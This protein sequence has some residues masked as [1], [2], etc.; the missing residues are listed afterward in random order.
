MVACTTATLVGLGW[1]VGGEVSTLAAEL[2][3][4]RTN[5]RAKVA[6]VRKFASGGTLEKV[7]ATIEGIGADLERSAGAAAATTPS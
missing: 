2:P 6:D 1:I 3:A 7:Q 4:Y 5:I